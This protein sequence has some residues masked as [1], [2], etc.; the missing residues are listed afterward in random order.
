M[1]F[2]D[3]FLSKNNTD[4][5]LKKCGFKK[6]EEN[7]FCVSYERY[8]NEFNYTHC[9]ELHL[10]SHKQSCFILSYEKG[11]NKDGFN[12]CVGLTVHEVSLI[13]NK[14]NMLAKQHNML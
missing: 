14:I 1:R 12:N 9:V 10:S 13:L 3:K 2:L 8:N 4:E 11:V 5:E 7:K 6:T